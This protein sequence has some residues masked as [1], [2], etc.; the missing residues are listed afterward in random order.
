MP[1]Y[2]HVGDAGFDFKA[3]DDIVIHSM[4]TLVVKTG[5]ACEIPTGFEMQ[6]RGRSGWN[7]RTPL[8]CKTGTIDSGYRGEIGVIL[9]NCGVD[10]IYIRAGEKIAQG[11]VAPVVYCEMVEAEELSD[12]SRGSGGF[13]HTGK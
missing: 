10:T 5:L 6:I 1:E 2:A 8:I 9:M 4:Q 12:S 3:L 11:V 13:G 7:S